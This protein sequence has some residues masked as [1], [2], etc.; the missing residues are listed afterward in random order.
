MEEKEEK[1]RTIQQNKALHKYFELLAKALNDAGLDMRVVLKPGV[2]IPWSKETIKEH[3]WRPIQNA[4]LGKKSTTELTT[5]EIDIVFDTINR[6]MS[7]KH[8]ISESFPSI[9]EIMFRL[10]EEEAKQSLNKKINNTIKQNG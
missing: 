7:E 3:I 8:G 6:H 2:A 10:R 5:K 9:E 1:Q 4:Q